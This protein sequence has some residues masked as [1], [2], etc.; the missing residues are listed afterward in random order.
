MTINLFPTEC[1]LPTTNDDILVIRYS[2][3]HIQLGWYSPVLGQFYVYGYKTD[4]SG[5]Q[6]VPSISGGIIVDDVIAWAEIENVRTY[7]PLPS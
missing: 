6:F 5:Q 7:R 1:K 3:L 2:S 4:D